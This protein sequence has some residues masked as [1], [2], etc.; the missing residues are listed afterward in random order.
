VLK[1]PAVR[2]G[3]SAFPC[4]AVSETLCSRDTCEGKCIFGFPYYH[5]V[6]YL[7]SLKSSIFNRLCRKL[8]TATRAFLGLVLAQLLHPFMLALSESTFK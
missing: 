6:T 1:S 8:D 5:N 4:I 2:M 7:L 3:L